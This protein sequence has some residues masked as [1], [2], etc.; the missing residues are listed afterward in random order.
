[1][2]FLL[3]FLFLIPLCLAQTSKLNDKQQEAWKKNQAEG[4]KKWRKQMAQDRQFIQKYF[5]SDLFKKFDKE[6]EKVLK[7]F[8]AA[9]SIQNFLGN[10]GLHKVFKGNKALKH[11]DYRWI[12]TPV[13]RILILKM[14]ILES[15]PFEIKIE[16]DQIIIKGTVIEKREQVTA[17]GSNF[18]ESSRYIEENFQVPRDVDS[19]RAVI[20]Q[21][22]G[23]ILIKIPKKKIP[24]LKAVPK[25]KDDVTI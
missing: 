16:S 11:S 6:I 24:G 12:E 9:G 23:E 22:K 8:D 7:G 1:M 10:G 15:K 21:S 14:S 13:Q 2:K 3:V 4:V 18:F 19:N 20:N 5:K 17:Q 25:S